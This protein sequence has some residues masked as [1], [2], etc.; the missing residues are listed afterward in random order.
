MSNGE[1]KTDTQAHKDRQREY[2]R[3]LRGTL[4]QVAAQPVYE[5]EYGNQS[6]DM[7]DAPGYCTAGNQRPREDAL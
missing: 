4:F 3:Q 7:I 1:R 5:D 2:A 6:M